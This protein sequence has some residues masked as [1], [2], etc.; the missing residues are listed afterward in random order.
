M[1]RSCERHEQRPGLIRGRL[2]E[3]RTGTLGHQ[4]VVL[5]VRRLTNACL[6]DQVCQ[7]G[8]CGHG[9]AYEGVHVTDAVGDVERQDHVAEAGVVVLGPE[10]HL[11]D[12][13][14]PHTGCA[15][16]VPPPF[17]APLV[18]VGVVP[19]PCLVDRTARHDGGPRRHAHRRRAVGRVVGGAAGCQRVK[20]RCA[21]DGAAIGTRGV[22]G[23]LIG[24]HDDDVWGLV[25]H[26][27]SSIRTREPVAAA[28]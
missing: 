16:H 8:S 12:D 23:V 19:R 20:V 5:E 4:S 11:P 22:P 3:P 25:A 10:V 2:V 28:R 7:R 17:G 26:A 14:R 13:G 27:R 1:M 18:R 15:K 6:P 24:H 9:I 21:N